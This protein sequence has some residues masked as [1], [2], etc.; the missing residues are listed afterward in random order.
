M[1]DVKYVWELNRLQFLHPVA[2]G[3]AATGDIDQIRWI[4]RILSS[5]MSANPPYRGINWTSGIE[6]SMRLVSFALLIAA[7][8]YDGME[9]DER[10]MMR[11]MIAAHGYWLRR[12]PSLHSSANNHLIAEGLGLFIAGLLVPDLPEADDWRHVG[13]CIVEQQTIKQILNDGVGA[14]QSPTYQALVMEMIALTAVLADEISEPLRH[15]TLDRL[16]LGAEYLH[17]ILDSEGV[18]PAI[19]DNDEGRTIAQPPD[20]EPRYIASVV[21]A[22]AGLT[23]HHCSPPH[24]SHIRDAIFSTPI[25]QTTALEGMR[26]FPIGGYSVVHDQIN[27]RIV[28]LIFDHG[29]LGYLSLAA[30][31]HADALSIWLTVNGIPI[32]IDAGTY[33]Y[34]SGGEARKRLRE[35]TTHNT[36]VVAGRSQST[37]AGPFVWT[38]K[39]HAFLMQSQPWPD[40][41]IT[42][43][44][45]GYL[46]E[47]RVHHVRRLEK[48]GDEVIV[49]DKLT[50]SGQALPVCVQFLCN[51]GLTV[52]PSDG[53]V[54]IF[55]NNAP[56][57]K[58]IAPKG[59]ETKIIIG[60]TITHSGW[61][62]PRF[63]TLV[64]APLV[65]LNGCLSNQEVL[66]RLKVLSSDSPVPVQN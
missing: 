32:F 47:F 64:P 27:R 60:D 59:F 54:I 55:H 22:I 56:I 62:S 46:D 65:T 58:I 66:T 6:L 20:P 43:G 35:T 7:V 48:N 23:G 36:L 31:G 8:G 37:V 5:W 63:G 39:A 11:R 28:D 33:L 41:S 57:L 44:Q 50:G 61:Y 17:W 49:F 30:H 18:A 42:A 3:V 45:D 29:P 40:W 9:R 16:I 15:S 13:R 52:I 25:K 26:I 53:D 24:D 34:H 14:E 38:A 19:G 1:G 4:F 12:Y 2:A 10:V 51:P 21:A